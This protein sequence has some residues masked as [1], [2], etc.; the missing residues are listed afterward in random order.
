[1]IVI[2]SKSTEVREVRAGDKFRLTIKDLLGSSVLIEEDI[3]A[4]FTADYIVSFRFTMEDGT[5]VGS[6]LAGMF[7]NSKNLPKEFEDAVMFEDLT[8]SQK[9]R[10]TNSSMN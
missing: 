5:L 2:T 9:E 4:D 6:H 7:G 1:M 10:L 3:T 8:D